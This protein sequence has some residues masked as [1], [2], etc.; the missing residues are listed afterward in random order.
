MKKTSTFFSCLLA[1]ILLFANNSFTSLAQENEEKE[2]SFNSVVEVESYSIEEEY[3]EPGKNA[4]ITVT[5]HNANT[6]SAVKSLLV[7]FSS[8]SGM[9]FPAY[10]EDNQ[11]FIGTLEAGKTTTITLPMV[12]SSKMTGDYVDL[13]LNMIYETDGSR[14]NNSATMVFPTKNNITVAVHSLDVSAHATVNGKSLLS[15]SYS[16]N[17]VDNINDASLTIDGKVSDATRKIELGNC[18]WWKDLYRGLQ[19]NFYGRRTAGGFN[20]S[21]L[22]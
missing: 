5:L 22:H 18:F 21:L 14:I 8:S 10:G 13:T 1:N 12:A 15:I 4:N 20:N 6:Y 17:G 16:N 9:L 7:V 11:T 2:L 19:Y 3:I